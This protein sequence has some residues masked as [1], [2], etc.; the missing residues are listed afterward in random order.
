MTLRRSIALLASCILLAAFAASPAFN[1]PARAQTVVD[2]IVA[3]VNNETLARTDLLW[4]IALD[5]TAPSPAGPV[6]SEILRRMLDTLIDQ[7]LIAQ[8]AARLPGAEVTAEDVDKYRRQLIESFRGGESAFRQR[9][10]S[11]GLTPERIDSIIRERI[12]IDRFVEF[13]FRSFVFISETEIK[14]YYD[15]V[16]APEVRKLGQVPPPL[17]DLRNDILARLKAEKIN[18]ELDR[19]IATARQRA[20]IVILVDL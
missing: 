19:F 1:P 4:N 12:E 11:V 16:L 2:Q 3:L 15:E 17:D 13:R 18:Q 7:R 14:R 5:P 9:V 20:E 8:E 10:A 6:G